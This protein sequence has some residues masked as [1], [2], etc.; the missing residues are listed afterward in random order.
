[1]PVITAT[2]V[3]KKGL[4]ARAAA[5]FVKTVSGFDAQVQVIKKAALAEA[6][7][8]PVGGSSILGLMMLG[9]DL[10]SVLLID[11]SGNEAEG[12]LAALTELVAGRFGE[13]E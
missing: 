11:A 8:A 3:N 4:H 6:D 13:A 10:G 5:K 12:V 1:M 2:I 9:A 7:S